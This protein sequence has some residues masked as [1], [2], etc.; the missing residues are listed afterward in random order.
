VHPVNAAILA[1][2]GGLYRCGKCNK[3]SNALESLFDEWPGAGGKPA[4]AGDLPTLG[5]EID[6]EQAGHSRLNP[7]GASLTGEMPEPPR[8]PS[9]A[10]HFFLRA[11]WLI[12]LLVV[13]GIIIVKLAEFSGHPVV[14]PEEIDTAL[15][16]LGIREAPEKPVFRDL[17]LIHLVSRE[18]A[19][20][21]A[22]PGQLKL[23]ATLVNRATK[24][25]P[26]PLLEVVL[27][28]A[29]GSQLATHYFEP[30]DYL[31][32]GS[33]PAATMS[34]HAYLP[35]SLQIEDP[36]VRAVGFELNFH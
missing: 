6:L 33:K 14:E 16:N 24:S 29:E 22:R 4:Q 32:G 12:G 19:A 10:G 35:L 28:D 2:N 17:G 26:Y 21:P 13:G 23:Q 20:D 30:A 15:V 7:E 36:G 34:P 27:F 9:R 8:T 25:Q 31:A 18:L 3:T 11:I 5:I 1:R